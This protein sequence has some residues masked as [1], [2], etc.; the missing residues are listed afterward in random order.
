M[1]NNACSLLESDFLRIFQETI[2]AGLPNTYMDQ[3]YSGVADTDEQR[4]QFLACLNND[5]LGPE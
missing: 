5:E 3:A 1:L 4:Q 2:K